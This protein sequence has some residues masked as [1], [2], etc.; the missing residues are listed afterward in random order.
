MEP[1]EKLDVLLACPRGYCA[2]V[3]RAIALLEEVL[4]K[5]K[6]PVYVYHELVHN[7]RIVNE[8]RKRGVHFVENIDEVPE[9]KTLLFSAHGVSPEIRNKAIARNLKT[10]NATCSLVARIHQQVV[11]YRKRG[12]HIILIGHEGHDEVVGIL[13][14]APDNISLLSSSDAIDSLNLPEGK[15]VTCVMQTTLSAEK[16]MACLTQLQ[17]RFPQLVLPNK[18][19]V[20][21]ATEEHQEAVRRSVPGRELVLV[22]GS[23]NSSNTKRL[24]E[25]AKELVDHSYLVDDTS[26]LRTEW[27]HNGQKI[28][29]TSGA[30]VPEIIVQECVEW[31]KQKYDVQLTDASL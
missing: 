17:N 2:G 4:I 25:L 3:K 30:S 10:I 8:F 12:F 24:W 6:H 27:F 15:P 23:Q 1:K 26:E 18:T 29:I 20:C 21:H 14:E 19:A 28:L 5:E 9:G 7:K 11:D 31:L 13:G 22:V 16:S